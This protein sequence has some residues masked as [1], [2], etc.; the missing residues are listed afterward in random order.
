MRMSFLMLFPCVLG[1]LATNPIVD[2]DDPVKL[3]FDDVTAGKLPK[4]WSIAETNGKGTKATWRVDADASAPSPKNVMKLAATKNTGDC[5]N[6][7]LSDAS[8]GPDVEISVKLRADA[9]DDD[10]GGGLAWRAK[11]AANYYI[12]RWNPLEKNLRLYKVVDG[13]RTQLKS[14]DIKCDAKSWHDLKV[15]SKGKKITVEFDGKAEIDV[16]D[17]SFSAAGKVALWTKA[18][19]ATS[20]DDLVITK[21]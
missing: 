14:A 18:D 7:L 19:A 4:D 1:V 13:K 17:E 11:D 10:Q 2:R 20:F 6:L 15:T 12:T 8:F 5:F 9:G 3:N 21:K 16:E